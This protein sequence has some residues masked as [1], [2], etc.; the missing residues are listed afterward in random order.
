MRLKCVAIVFSMLV[1]ILYENGARKFWIY[2]TGP[3]GCLPQTLALRKKNDS[4]L[5]EFGCMAEYND[6]AKAFNAGLSDLCDELRSK[7]HKATVVYTD[8]YTIR[9]DLVANH[10]KYGGLQMYKHNIYFLSVY[11][12]NFQLRNY[13]LLQFL[14][15]ALKIR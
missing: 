5:D 14:S 1:Q 4:V 11:A 2:N 7:Y 13:L 12:L 9:Y 10:T 6:A 3:L 15:Q 8:K